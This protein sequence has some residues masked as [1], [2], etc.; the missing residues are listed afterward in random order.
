MKRPLFIIIGAVVVLI[1]IA[2]WI[3]VLF[4]SVPGETD[5]QFTDLNLGNTT[6]INYVPPADTIEINN[7]AIVNVGQYNRLK[8]LTTKPVA[9]F[10]E[11]QRDN[12]P[13]EVLYVEAGT[14]HIFSIDLE[15]GEEERVSATTIAS[16]QSAAFS[17][18]GQ[19]VL[20]QSGYG[21]GSTITVGTLST[22]SDQLRTSIIYDNVISFAGT[23]SGNFLY[24]E[25]T[26][27]SVIGKSY[28]PVTLNTTTLFTIP[29]REA[30]IQWGEEVTDAHYVYPKATSQLEGFL[31]E[32]KNGV[33]SRLPVDGY[34]LS[35]QG[36][37]DY[38]LYS[39]VNDG[40]YTSYLYDRTTEQIQPNLFIQV[41]EKCAFGSETKSIS[42]CANTGLV[43][44][45]RMPE[46]WYAGDITFSDILYVNQNDVGQS[47]RLVD[48]QSE[49]NQNIDA[50]HLDLG[51]QDA[52]LYFTNKNDNTL[53]LYELS[54]RALLLSN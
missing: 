43:Y 30:T 7:D 31:Y 36:N 15:T 12:L 13:E 49:T 45:N 8:Q 53:W 29:F 1:L 3:Y 28:N 2:V 42:V 17:A 41:P 6:D 51:V 33:L 40:E 21:F 32:V 38:V 37:D 52:F 23:P 44:N 47:I 35:A 46:S 5:E 50:I 54:P 34:G 25:Q 19:H 48:T 14:G 9:G 4:F 24:A 27:S 39:K 11:V 16:S 22:T 10:T 18:N 20:V 26:N